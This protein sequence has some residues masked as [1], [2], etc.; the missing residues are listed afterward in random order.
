M[1]NLTSLSITF[2]FVGLF[3]VISALSSQAEIPSSIPSSGSNNISP[4]SAKTIKA[5]NDWDVF[6]H[7]L[8]HSLYQNFTPPQQSQNKYAIFT[9]TIQKD[10]QVSKI[11]LKQSSTDPSYDQAAK[12]AIE[13]AAPFPRF[14][15]S[16]KQ[17]FI[18]I[19]FIF[20]YSH[21]SSR[22]F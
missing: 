22:K 10:G 9:F 7:K 20:D 5:H 16:Y 2:L 4:A 3:F 18:T 11:I 6:I 1:P 19:E 13:A 14:P 8:K 15:E 21:L 17:E 12:R